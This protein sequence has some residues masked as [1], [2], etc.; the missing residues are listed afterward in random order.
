[1]RSQRMFQVGFGLLLIAGT[2]PWCMATEMAGGVKDMVLVPRGEFTMGSREHADEGAHQVVLD[3][4]YIDKYEASNARYK[5]FMRATG[6]PAPAYWDDPRL[7]KPNQPVVGVSWNDAAA[8]C[9]WEG[10]RLPTEAE[11]ERAAKGPEGDNH[12]PWGHKLDPKKANYGQNVGRTMP[13]DSYPEGVSGFGVYNMAGNVFE[14]VA[15]W[16]DPKYYKESLALNPQGPQKGY[17]FANQGAVRVLRGGSWLAPETS[18]HTSHRF[19]NQPENNSYGVGL[20][21]RCAKAG[22]AVSDEA[23]QAG[24]EAFIQALISMGAEKQADAMAWIEKALAADPGNKEYLTTRD[25]VKKSM[26][27]K[28]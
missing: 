10:K 1:M 7:S 20:G 3:P 25:L 27:N 5:E 6:H 15:D 23:I 4:Y 2:A 21:F 26:N 24:R 28:H 19:W 12:Y 9:T 16:Y 22:P 14:W 18:L 11:W 13:V 17:N 8:F